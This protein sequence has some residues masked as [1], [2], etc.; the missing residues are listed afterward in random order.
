[1]QMTNVFFIFSLRS[2]VLQINI[3]HF[4]RP[5]ESSGPIY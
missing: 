2:C 1:M 5:S 3:V 4:Y